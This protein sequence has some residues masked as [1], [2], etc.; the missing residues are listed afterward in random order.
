MVFP[1]SSSIRKKKKY[2]RKKF[3]KAKKETKKKKEQQSELGE[4]YKRLRPKG[5]K[6]EVDVVHGP[7]RPTGGVPVITPHSEN[8]FGERGK[9]V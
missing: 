3:F 6:V 1:Q 2:A 5:Y 7:V 8:D 4:T 9:G